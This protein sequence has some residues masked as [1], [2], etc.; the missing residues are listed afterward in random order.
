MANLPLTQYYKLAVDDARPFYHIY[1]GT[2]DNGTHGGTTRTDKSQGI[3]NEDWEVVL[4]ADGHQPA[5]EPGNPNIMYAESQEGFLTRI[6]LATHEGISIQPQPEDGEGFERFNW[7]SP[8]LVSPHSPTRI[9]FASQRLW[10]SEN[11]GDSWTAISGDLTRNQERLE[12]PIMDKSWSWDAPWDVYAMST[13]NTITSIAESPV[14]ENLLYAG[15]DDGFIHVTE[16]GGLNWKKIEVSNLPDVPGT[17]F[18]NDIKADLFD[19]NTVYVALDNHKYGDL[20]PYLFKSTNKGKTWK[21]ISSNIP[22]KTLV[23][24]IVQDH[25]KKDLLF[26]ATEFGIYF[27]VDGGQKWI[28]IKGGVPTIS[29]RDLVIQ[30][31]ENDLVCA[32]FGRSFYVFDD[33]S[34]LRNV[35]KEQLNE[36]ATLFEVRDAD[37]YV[38]GLGKRTQGASFFVAK[39]PAY[40]ATF[41]YYLKDGF[42]TKQAVRKANEGKLIKENKD[43]PFPG[44]DA[45]EAEKRQ[46]TPKIWL[47]I[48]NDAGKIVRQLSGPTAKGFNRMAWDLRMSHAN[49]VDIN[50]K[51][52]NFNRGGYSKVI[53]GTFTVSLSKEVDGVITEL[54][55]P[56]PFDVVPLRTPSLKGADY[57]SV[58]DF[59]QQLTDLEADMSVAELEVNKTMKQVT[60]MELALSRATNET[61]GLAKELYQIKQDLY[62]IEFQLKGY[63]TKKEIGEKNSPTIN[64]RVSAAQ[65][66]V[67]YSTYGPT[68]TA[69][70]SLEIAQTRFAGVKADLE[71]M[72]EVRLPE[73]EKKLLAA[74][75]PIVK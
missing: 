65:R 18:V 33:Y 7:D 10:R 39:N 11:R 71:S 20:N 31:R 21:S 47:T 30:R 62:E 35:S 32:S 25:I 58:A 72:V 40:G 14:Q 61:N 57:A 29:F 1:G 12:L 36:E 67:A 59:W 2:Q 44:W 5:T 56:V 17:A 41:T 19:A 50:S 15:T 22:K 74:G 37:W 52:T 68:E 66:A 4:W 16:D 46:A 45:L 48:K 27:T 49:V 63:K 70:K 73:I 69:I 23:W 8:I 38:P 24:R 26:A 9:Y 55:N 60:A 53:P 75:A 28:K 54:S 13:Y 6:D 34:V 64:S 3:T 42:K 43:I 51:N